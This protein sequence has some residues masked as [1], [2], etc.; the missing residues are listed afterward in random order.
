VEEHLA[1]VEAH[2][3]TLA[4]THEI[5]ETGADS[6]ISLFIFVEVLERDQ[7]PLSTSL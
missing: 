6:I 1:E 2:A 4:L 5:V 7:V 3:H